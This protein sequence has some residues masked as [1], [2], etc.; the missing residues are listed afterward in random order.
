MGGEVYPL[1]RGRRRSKSTYLCVGSR[2]QEWLLFYLLAQK[3]VLFMYIFEQWMVWA[4]DQG[5]EKL[6]G[7]TLMQFIGRVHKNG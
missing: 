5:F 6:E 4:K 7:E 3:Q 1:L 2:S